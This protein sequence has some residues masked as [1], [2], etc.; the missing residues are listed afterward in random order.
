[1]TAHVV[2]VTFHLAGGCFVYTAKLYRGMDG[3]TGPPHSLEQQLCF[4]KWHFVI[5]C[6]V[7]ESELWV[8][9]FAC[10]CTCSRTSER[11]CVCDTDQLECLIYEHLTV[12]LCLFV[13]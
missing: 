9:A 2:P 11:V 3:V 6:R 5:F 1:M 10:A 7:S 12:S 8:C 13:A 4:N